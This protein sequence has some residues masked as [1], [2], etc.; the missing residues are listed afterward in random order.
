MTPN[1][2]QQ[3]K[4]TKK[5]WLWK[6]PELETT[7]NQTNILIITSVNFFQ[8]FFLLLLF[9]VGEMKRNLIL[10]HDPNTSSVSMRRQFCC[11][12]PV[13]RSE[14]E[15]EPEEASDIDPWWTRGREE[16]IEVRSQEQEEEDEE[17]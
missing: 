8:G 6:G 16:I 10:H 2:I 1:Q 4:T 5:T 15:P 9:H 3:K 7:G 12:W 14:R 13:L 17:D 11:Y